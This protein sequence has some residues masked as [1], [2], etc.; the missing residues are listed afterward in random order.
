MARGDGFFL[1][2]REETAGGKKNIGRAEDAGS[3]GWRS[4]GWHAVTLRSNALG[5]KSVR[6]HM[7]THGCAA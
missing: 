4:V 6:S 3:F 5:M 7:P 2:G 1:R